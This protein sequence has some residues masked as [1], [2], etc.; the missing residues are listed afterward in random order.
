MNDKNL[1]F[2]I[3]LLATPVVAFVP[4]GTDPKIDSRKSVTNDM[5]VKL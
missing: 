4:S 1:S 2:L 5:T 3:A